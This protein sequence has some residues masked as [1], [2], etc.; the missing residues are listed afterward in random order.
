MAQSEFVGHTAKVNL[1]A[2]SFEICHSK[3][4]NTVQFYDSMCHNKDKG[5][6]LTCNAICNALETVPHHSIELMGK[7]A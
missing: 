6:R 2:I 7:L 4:L 3:F 1:I 5:D